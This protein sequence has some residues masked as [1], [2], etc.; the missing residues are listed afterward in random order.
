MGEPRYEKASVCSEYKNITARWMRAVDIWIEYRAQNHPM[1]SSS[2]LEAGMKL[3]R[4]ATDI[5][6]ERLEHSFTCKRCQS[7]VSHSEVREGQE[8]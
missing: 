6:L 2:G 3:A 4:E 8:A 5:Y 1:N 7:R